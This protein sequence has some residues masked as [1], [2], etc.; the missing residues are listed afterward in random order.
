MKNSKRSLIKTGI[1]III[2]TFSIYMLVGRVLDMMPEE[3]VKDTAQ[4]FVCVYLYSEFS[5]VYKKEKEKSKL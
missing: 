2:I 4:V 3:Y 5:K 1:V